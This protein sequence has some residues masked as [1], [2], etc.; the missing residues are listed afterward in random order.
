MPVAVLTPF[1]RGRAVK[2]GDL[3]WRKKVLP[4]GD[5]EY[6][7]RTLHFTE[8]YLH[9]LAQSFTSRAYDQVP[10][11]LADGQN[12]HTNDPER[13][14][15]TIVSMDAQP[16]GLWVTLAPTTDGEKTLLDN[17]QLG[18]SARI[19][20]DY[21]R[22]DGKYFPAAVQHVLGTLDPRIPGLGGWQ[23]DIEMSNGGYKIIDLSGAQFSGEEGDMP[24]LTDEQNER[25][26]QLLNIPPEKFSSLIAAVS[27]PE[28]TDEELASLMGNDDGES[29]DGL[30]DEELA[31]LLSA[32]AE[33]DA[34]GLLEPE[35]VGMS[36]EQQMAIEM[37]NARTEATEFHL[38]NIQR[39]LDA[40]KF[41]K[42]KLELADIGV[43][44]FIV[45]LARPLLLGTGHVVDLSNGQSVDAGLVMRKVLLEYA[46]AAR[47]LD[48]GNEMGSAFDEPEGQSQAAESRA[49]VVDLFKRQTGL[50]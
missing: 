32:A 14:R 23:P 5:V 10:F 20:E 38:S 11:Q 2:S 21:A 15:G 33:L 25:L 35:G 41:S 19:V 34:E 7:G 28:L 6:Q 17:P 30:S 49:N 13:F 24:N 8:E 4:V 1:T 22:S 18:V 39:Q 37:A 44:P 27:A 40:E 46:K 36:A 50:G 9:Q 43:P 26:A 3:L 48:L 47:M 29:G 45:D 16:D 42:E 31:E 12:T